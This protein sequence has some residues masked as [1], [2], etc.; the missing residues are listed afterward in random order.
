MKSAGL[1]KALLVTSALHLPRSLAVARAVGIEG[2]QKTPA[3]ASQRRSPTA[4]Y[5]CLTRVDRDAGVLVEGVGV[6]FKLSLSRW[7]IQEKFLATGEA[8]IFRG[9]VKRFLPRQLAEYFVT[10]VRN[11]FHLAP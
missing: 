1:R 5:L 7:C 3:L 11:D 4:Q 2:L 9:Y 10:M 6:S 8:E